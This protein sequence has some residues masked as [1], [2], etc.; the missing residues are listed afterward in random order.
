M[1]RLRKFTYWSSRVIKS[2]ICMI[3]W[4]TEQF[5]DHYRGPKYLGIIQELDIELRSKVEYTD[6]E[7]SFDEAR[8]ILWEIAKD[9]GLQL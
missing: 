7:G 3:V 5:L 6:E 1:F 2:I 9:R 8:D 4:K